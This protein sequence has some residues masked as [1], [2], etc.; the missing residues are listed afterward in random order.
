M[1]RGPATTTVEVE[2]YGASY[3]VRGDD[4]PDHLH[5]LA[6]FVDEKMREIATQTATVDT[7]KIA[8]LAAL[9]IANELWSCREGEGQEQ[10]QV[11]DKV[12]ELAG[13]LESALEA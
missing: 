1:S 10:D 7:T 4:D 2:I 9:N 8:I 11:S 3:K 13:R 5:E 6:G 12:A